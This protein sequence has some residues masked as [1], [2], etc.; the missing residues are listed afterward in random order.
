[1]FFSVLAFTV[2]ILGGL[3]LLVVVFSLLTISQQ[4][5]DQAEKLSAMG[6]EEGQWE[7][8]QAMVEKGQTNQEPLEK[9]IRI[10]RMSRT[11]L[12]H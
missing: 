8:C 5:N 11:G 4:A 6:W 10:P 1:M 7:G 3:M 9:M 12:T 2:G